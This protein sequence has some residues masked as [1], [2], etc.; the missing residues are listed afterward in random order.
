MGDPVV[1][2][3]SP[4]S[5]APGGP[6]FILTVNGSGF[7]TTSLVQWNGATLVTTFVSS[8]QLTAQVEAFRIAAL[9]TVTVSVWNSYISLSNSVNFKVGAAPPDPPVIS[10]VSPARVDAGGAD[11]IMTVTGR[12]FRSGAAV[13]WTCSPLMQT[14]PLATIT[15][16]STQLTVPIP[17]GII[18]TSGAC[19]LTVKNLDGSTSGSW[20]FYIEPVLTSISPDNAQAALPGATITANGVGFVPT[21]YLALNGTPL[22]TSYNVSTRLMA[23]IPVSLMPSPGPATIQVA[24]A[25]GTASRTLPFTITGTSPPPPANTNLYSL[26]VSAVQAG[27]PDIVLTVGGTGLISG[28]TVVFGATNLATTYGSSTQVTATLPAALIAISGK[29]NL[30]VRRPDGASSNTLEFDVKPVL[31]SLSPASAGAGSQPLPLAATGVGFA[32]TNSLAILRAG[33]VTPIPT[34]YVN[35][36]TLTGIIPASALASAASATIQVMDSFWTGDVVLPF[37]ITG[38]VPPSLASLSPASIQAGGAAFTLTVNG[39][40]FVPGS[41]VQWNASFLT[42]T[43]VS[44]TQLK[45]QVEAFR[46]AGAA[47]AAVNVWNPDNSLSGAI[48]FVVNGAT[49]APGIGSV[50]PDHVDAG[51]PLQTFTIAG[52]NFLPGATVYWMTTALATTFVSAS[53]LT[54]SVP[55]ALLAGSGIFSLT[56]K[57]ADGSVSNAFRQMY[58]QPVLASLSPSSVAVGSPTVTITAKGSGFAPTNFLIIGTTRPLSTTYVDQET[59][60]ATVPA[61]QLTGVSDFP[62]SVDDPSGTS[63]R[64]LS[65]LVNAEVISSLQPAATGAGGPGFTLTI[66]GSNF[67]PGTTVAWKNTPLAATFVSSVQLTADVPA[68]LIASAGDVI[69][70][71]QNPGGMTFGALFTVTPAAGPVITTVN[72]GQFDAG[73][74]ASLIFL[75]GTGILDT[76][77]VNWNGT[78]LVTAWNGPGRVQATVPASLLT[79]SGRFNVTVS[80]PDGRTS[81]SF[82]E[83][84]EPLLQGVGASPVS[85]STATIRAV[86]IGFVPT[87]VLRVVVAGAQS[88]L[89][90]TFVSSNTPTAPVP[91]S[92]LA[93]GANISVSVADPAAG[94]SSRPAT[95]ST[96]LPGLA[97]ASLSPGTVTVG[98]PDFTLTV[99]G[100]GFNTS[101][102]VLWNGAALSTTYVSAAQV[103]A[104][105]PY[106]L[107]TQAANIAI[108]VRNANQ[109]IS[110]QLNFAVGSA[111][112]V[113]STAG[114]VN[115][116][117]GLPAIAPGSLAAI[118]GSNLSASTAQASDLPLPR[119][120]GETSVLIN[121]TAVPLLFV[122]PGQIN[123][124]VPSEAVP[125]KA[126]LVVRS[127]G[128]DSAPVDFR[129]APTGPGVMTLLL[130][131]HAL[132]VN[133]PD[134]SLNSAQNPAHPGQYVMV[135]VTGQGQVQPPVPSGTA[136]PSNP[137]STPLYP[138][139]V[140]IGGQPAW[141]FAV[142]APGYVGLMQ[143]NVIVPG[144]AAGEQ[145]FEVTIGGVAA[146]P[147]TISIGQ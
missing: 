29:Y 133:L 32:P 130:T 94:T 71:V 42:T 12:N 62:I 21:N 77:V 125:D 17:G 75:A 28:S 90:T 7:A 18:R 108:T 144:V 43:F 72:P 132:V 141:A 37:A 118:Y 98:G 65:F 121:G 81:P 59:V 93:S 46:I 44:A 89:A 3:I 124:Q 126:R 57:N 8:T 100:T 139:E 19:V 22:P 103:A 99:G 107:I 66:N 76:S 136:A 140:R 111:L 13:S 14:V 80:N 27:S 16:S 91:A 134:G 10:G 146:N 52:S 31:R 30:Y 41:Q 135:Y 143:M 115:V 4:A 26:N 39:S 95:F 73:Q 92:A 69:I 5:A 84:V 82:V 74:A 128:V 45:A 48:T 147:T 131:N 145:P 127:G 23:T 68:S 97:I 34:S 54:A 67:L 60:T 64:P 117:S 78:P 6:P 53:Q 114:I 49:A 50:S 35:S 101:S 102:T 129:I 79:T 137:L 119:T 104:A 51:G 40:G 87:D 24:D 116:A 109:T 38:S 1:T 105:V 58:V 61:N 70:S 138:V 9:G 15:T 113:T 47:G 123:I 83:Y 112:P 55:G 2:S 110:N 142:M 33:S 96:A 88:D 36:T 85:G 122:S 106:G 20:T 120:L 11:F 86:G 25:S 56:V 63:S